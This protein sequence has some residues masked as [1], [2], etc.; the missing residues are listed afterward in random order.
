MIMA[1]E[2]VSRAVPRMLKETQHRSQPEHF[3]IRLLHKPIDSGMVTC[4]SII[5]GAAK[6]AGRCGT[7]YLNGP[8]R[9]VYPS[10][11]LRGCDGDIQQ[12]TIIRNSGN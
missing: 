3:Q 2:N 7:Y 9:D 12:N 11:K 10:V 5:I 8:A 6:I 4:N 1:A